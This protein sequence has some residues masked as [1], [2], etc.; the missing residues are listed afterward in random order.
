[1][2]SDNSGVELGGVKMSMNPFC[3][4]AIEEAVRLKEKKHVVEIIALTIGPKQNAE[5]LRTALALGADKAIHILTELRPDQAL[6]PIHVAQ[7]L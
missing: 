2:K 6:Q 7:V 3:E 1:V 4:I 5:T